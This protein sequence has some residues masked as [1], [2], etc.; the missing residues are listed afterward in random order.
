MLRELQLLFAKER[1]LAGKI[2]FYEN[3]KSNEMF[4]DRVIEMFV[5]KSDRNNGGKSEAGNLKVAMKTEIKSSAFER[6]LKL[7]AEYNKNHGRILKLIDT[8]RAHD[9]DGRRLELDERKHAVA[10]QRLTGEYRIDPDTGEL[11]D[12]PVDGSADGS[13]CV[14]EA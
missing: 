12:R 6:L 1:D 11:D 14:V 2:N 5:P 7:E 13:G 4:V 8:I 10:K 3:A 9:L